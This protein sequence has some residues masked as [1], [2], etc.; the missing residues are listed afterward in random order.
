MRKNGFYLLTA[1]LLGI[2]LGCGTGCACRQPSVQKP[3]ATAKS[4]GKGR[5]NSPKM[6][7]AT[8]QTA[9]VVKVNPGARF[10][11]LNFPVGT[12]PQKGATYLLFRNGLQ[13]GEARISGPQLD[14][15]VVADLTAG[16]AAANDEARLP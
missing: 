1:A 10:V 4:K 14:D 8:D 3:P 7:V 13:V 2:A 12:L 15:N 16:E 6:V 11:V 9:T 5:T